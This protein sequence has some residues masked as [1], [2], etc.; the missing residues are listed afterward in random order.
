LDQAV[1][2]S[3]EKTG[4]RLRGVV[5]FAISELGE[6]ERFVEHEAAGLADRKPQLAAR[7]RAG[8]LLGLDDQI[9]MDRHLLAMQEHLVVGSVADGAVGGH[10]KRLMTRSVEGLGTSNALL[11]RSRDSLEPGAGPMRN[12]GAQLALVESPRRLLKGEIGM[13]GREFGCR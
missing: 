5:V 8:V 7:Q 1:E 3:V 9:L 10:R 2:I 6:V 12:V 4:E 11:D 13:R